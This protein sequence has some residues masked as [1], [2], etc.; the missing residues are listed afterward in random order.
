LELLAT[1][2]LAVCFAALWLSTPPLQLLVAAAAAL[3]ALSLSIHS[4]RHVRLARA[5]GAGSVR[6]VQLGVEIRWR[7][8]PR[9]AAVAGLH[10][11]SI[12]CDPR[13]RQSLSPRELR[14]V[15]LHER[16]HQLRRDPLRLLLL[17]SVEPVVRLA[18]RGREWLERSRAHLEIAADAYALSQGALRADLA[19]AILKLGAT[20]AGTAAAFSSAVELRLQALTGGVDP[21]ASRS[22]ASPRWGIAVGV[23][24]LACAMALAHEAI[25]LG[26][27]AVCALP[28]C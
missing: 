4:W 26:L 20:P 5:L 14:A 17:A 28:I 2:A 22:A 12:F 11:P 23:V 7:S 25:A 3:L 16:C 10:R 18:P 1:A 9:V 6:D 13:L 19:G 24:S 21:S 27:P 15:L 8:S